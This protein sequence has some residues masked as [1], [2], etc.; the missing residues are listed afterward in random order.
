MGTLVFA[1]VLRPH[2]DD[3][4]KWPGVDLASSHSRAAS[5]T[6]S[7]ITVYSKRSLAPTLPATTWPAA[8]PMPAS[9]SGTSSRMP[10]GDGAG[11]GQRLVL[12][13]VQVIRGAEHGQRRITLELVDQPVVSVHLLD[14][15]REESVEQL[16]DLGRRPA[17]SPAGWSR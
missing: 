16:N 5:L 7:P 13:T 11:G 9:H 10:L 3:A 14:D 6:G 15:D 4:S 12:G 17:R 2:R 1:R 8:T